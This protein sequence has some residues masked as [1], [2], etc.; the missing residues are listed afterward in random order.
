VSVNAVPTKELHPSDYLIQHCTVMDPQL[1]FCHTHA[2]T[3]ECGCLTSDLGYINTLKSIHY[4]CIVMYL[5]VCV[6]VHACVCVFF[7]LL[8]Y[9]HCLVSGLLGF[10][11]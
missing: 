8:C 1:S 2:C 10:G 5:Y 6:C 3:H 11:S 9:G 7:P 4:T